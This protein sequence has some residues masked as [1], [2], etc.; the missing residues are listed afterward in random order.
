M[1]IGNGKR[2]K[3]IGFMACM[4]AMPRNVDHVHERVNLLSFRFLTDGQELKSD[5]L[6]TIYIVVCLYSFLWFVHHYTAI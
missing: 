5:S 4:S 2:K 6:E 3:V 1:T